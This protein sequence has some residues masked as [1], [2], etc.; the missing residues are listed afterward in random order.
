M[1]EYYRK[2]P[3]FALLGGLSAGDWQPMHE[4]SEQHKIPCLLPVTDLPVISDTDWYTLYFSKGVYQEGESAARYLGLNSDPAGDSKV[5]QVV[6]DSPRA[7]AAA[8]GFLNA[9]KELGRTAPE[10]VYLAPGESIS[11]AKIRTLN[12]QKQPGLPSCSGP[13]PGR[14]RPLMPWLRTRMHRSVVHV[15]TTLLGKDLMKH[16]GKGAGYHLHQLSLP[17]G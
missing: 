12:G 14:S 5:L 7:R 4:F 1:E 10:T 13:L 2:E 9:W 16:P 11:A 6:E 8:A 3:V 15:S 17:G